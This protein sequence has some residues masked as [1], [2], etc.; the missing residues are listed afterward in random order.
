MVLSWR[1]TIVLLFLVTAACATE[2]TGLG[3]R[4]GSAEVR[5]VVDGDTLD[6]TLP[7]GSE[8]VR[9]LGIDT[10]ESVKPNTPVQCYAR[11]AS[12]RLKALLP[13]RTPIRLVPDTEKGDRY[14]RVLAYVYRQADGLFVNL[15]LVRGGYARVLTFRPNVAH[16]PEFE[17]AA[18][19]AR[20][21]SR[22]L[23]ETCPTATSLPP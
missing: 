13:E 6:V 3:P 1:S 9:L 16:A 2:P 18:S 19:Q 10:P 21:S 14:G 7:G 23:W 8:R 15:D 5:R 20:R 12:A 11:E 22:G 17:L 4:F